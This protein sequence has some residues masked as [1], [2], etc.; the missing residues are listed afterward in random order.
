MVPNTLVLLSPLLMGL[1]PSQPAEGGK[2]LHFSYLSFPLGLVFFFFQII[3]SRKRGADSQTP[4]RPS[5]VL[6]A[7][8][9]HL[10]RRSKK[11][12]RSS[13][14]QVTGLIA[15]ATMRAGAAVDGFSRSPI[16]Y[17]LRNLLWCTRC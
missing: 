8:L 14:A 5:L 16:L 17:T 7:H 11:S 9:T 6:A 1:G 4:D 2:K 13:E 15:E 3:Q 12:S 10:F